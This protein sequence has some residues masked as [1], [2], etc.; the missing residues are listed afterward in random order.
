MN[1]L[2]WYGVAAGIVAVVLVAH[3]SFAQ[4]A[5]SDAEKLAG[6]P[7]PTFSLDL[8]GGGTFNLA[9]HKGKD[10]VV[11]DFWAT[12]CP[13]CRMLLPVMV[14]VTNK[15]KDKGVVFVAVN[16]SEKPETVQAYREKLG[17]TF[18]VALDK[19]QAVAEKYHVE[20]IPQSV[21]VGKDGT[22][23]SVHLGFGPDSDK[24]IAKELDA[25]LAAKDK[26]EEPKKK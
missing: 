13:P 6:K 20:S 26:K 10:I 11:L 3:G 1:R 19:D 25:L 23:E 12:W 9:D 21:I 22:I 2:A 15:Y 8:L 17:K 24:T 18:N 4:L 14:D 5:P 16:L 7:A